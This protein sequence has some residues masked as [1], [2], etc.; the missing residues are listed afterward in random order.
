MNDRHP[1]DSDRYQA[2][3]ALIRRL[4]KSKALEF[5]TSVF[6]WDPSLAEDFD[7]TEHCDGE[8][9]M[10][11]ANV[12]L[13][14]KKK[15]FV[16]TERGEEATIGHATEDGLDGGGV[17]INTWTRATLFIP[18]LFGTRDHDVFVRMTIRIV[19]PPLRKDDEQ[20][21]SNGDTAAP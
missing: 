7:D 16:S 11:C 13:S 1:S 4:S 5:T 14:R 18:T 21:P 10:L 20:K 3:N 2:E 8:F 6:P 19:P 9:E 15:R 12:T 17:E